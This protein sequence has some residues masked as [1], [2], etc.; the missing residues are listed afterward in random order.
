MLFVS[1]ITAQDPLKENRDQSRRVFIIGGTGYLGR[2]LI[3]VLVQKGH[4]VHALVRAGSESKLPSG[5]THTII[6]NPLDWEEVSLLQG[7]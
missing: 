5:C 2:S 7:H 3:P 1:A 4:E 6:G